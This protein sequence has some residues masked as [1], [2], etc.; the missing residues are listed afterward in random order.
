M[1]IVMSAG[2]A[3]S[4]CSPPL[5]WCL[6]VFRQR[7]ERGSEELLKSVGKAEGH[8]GSVGRPFGASTGHDSAGERLLITTVNPDR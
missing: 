5:P 1:L 3:Y 6:Q 2:G 7:T 8:L 4:L